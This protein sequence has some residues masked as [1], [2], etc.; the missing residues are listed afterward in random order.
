MTTVGRRRRF[1]RS[2]ANGGYPPKAAV[3]KPLKSTRCR[4]IEACTSPWEMQGIALDHVLTSS[5]AL[6]ANPSG[7]WQVRQHQPR[8]SRVHQWRRRQ[9]LH[10]A[11]PGG[12]CGSRCHQLGGRCSAARL[13][14]SRASEGADGVEVGVAGNRRG[15]ISP[16]SNFNSWI[17]SSRHARNSTRRSLSGF[18]PLTASRPSSQCQPGGSGANEQRGCFPVQ[19]MASH[20]SDS[21]VVPDTHL[22]RFPYL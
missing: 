5:K 15:D 18:R 20:S 10:H 1:I 7:G 6:G 22:P 2:P 4:R 9:Q 8:R 12:R 17:R 3:A 14:P 19:R 11:P 13:R 21:G 16:A